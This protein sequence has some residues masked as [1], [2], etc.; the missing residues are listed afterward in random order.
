VR[1]AIIEYA[2]QSPGKL[3]ACLLPWRERVQM[4]IPGFLFTA[5][6]AILVF[7]IL[8]AIAGVVSRSPEVS[9]SL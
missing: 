3:F 1:N 9:G 7:S 5:A 6:I 8:A 2:E 4:L